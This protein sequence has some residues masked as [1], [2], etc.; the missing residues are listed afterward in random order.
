MVNLS[1]RLSCNTPEYISIF[2]EAIIQPDR[3]EFFG[4]TTDI[5]KV[6]RLISNCHYHHQY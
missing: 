5:H 1:L 6:N 2:A 3:I 4:G